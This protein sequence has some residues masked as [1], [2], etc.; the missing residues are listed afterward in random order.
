[1]HIP[2]GKSWKPIELQIITRILRTAS[3]L[4]SLQAILLLQMTIVKIKNMHYKRLRG[5]SNL[6]PKLL[7]QCPSAK[8]GIRWEKKTKTIVEKKRA[9]KLCT[10]V[11]LAWSNPKHS[12]GFATQKGWKT[13]PSSCLSSMTCFCTRNCACIINLSQGIVALL[14]S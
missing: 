7:P 8:C 13:Q 10:I 12:S 5:K 4:A 14:R 3:R 9:N 11:D 2:R 1:M 6:L